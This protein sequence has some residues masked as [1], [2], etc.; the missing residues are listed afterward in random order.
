M[1]GVVKSTAIVLLVALLTCGSAFGQAVSQ[2]GG[3]TKDQSGAVVPGVQVTATQTDTGISRTA[4][5]NDAGEFVLPNLPT[6]PYRIEAKKTGFQNYAQSGIVLQVDSAPTIAITLGVGA[7]TQT[8]EVQANASQVETEKLG[9]GTVME[10]QRVLDLPLNGRNPTDLVVLTPG[11]VQTATSPAYGM[12]TGVKIAIAGGLDYGTFYALDGAPHMNLYDATNMPLPFP[13][14]LQEFKV[15]TSTQN[16]EVGVHAGGQVNAVTKSG[17]NSFHG[18]AFEFFR[19]GDLNAR[20][21]FSPTQDNLKRNQFGGVVG[22]PIRKNRLFF[23]GGYQGTELRQA[24]SP[25]QDYVPTPAM[26]TGDFSTF[27]SAGCQASGVQLNLKAPFVNNQIPQSMINP[28][29]LKIASYLPAAENQC[30]LF[31]T[32][33]LLS[34]YFWQVPLKID[35]QLNEK[36]NIFFRYLVT[37]QNQANPYSL[38]PKNI[39]SA[40]GNSIDDRAWDAVLGH[41][42]LISPTMINSLRFSINRTL[43]FHGGSSYFGPSQ[44]GMN[45][46]TYTPNAMQIAV[47]GDF[48]VGSGVDANDWQENSSGSV[49]DDFTLIKGKHQIAFGADLMRA[50]AISMANVYSIGSYSVTGAYTGSGLG[51]LFSGQLASVLQSL[52]NDLITDQWFFGAYAQ[53]TWKV[54]P[55]LTATFGLRWEP[56]LPFQDRDSHIYEFSLA[57]FYANQVSKVWTNAPPGFTYPGD[58]GFN[59]RSAMNAVWNDFAPRIGLAW[60]PFGDGKTSIRAGAGIGYDFFNSQLYANPEN[61][62]PFSGQTTLPGPLPLANPW[63]SIGGDPFPAYNSIPPTGDF[64]AGSAF[65]PVPRNLPPTRVYNWN[66]AIQRQITPSWFSSI[67]YMG[68]QGT[69]LLDMLNE[70]P[71]EFVPGNCV[72]GQYGLTAPGPCTNTANVNNRRLLTLA[73]PVAAAPIGYVSPFDAG[74]TSSYEGLVLATNYRMRQNLSVIANYTYSHC[75]SLNTANVLGDGTGNWFLYYV[76]QNDRNEDIGNCAQD[77]RVIANVTAVATMPKFSNRAVNLIAS[78][79]QASLLYRWSSGAPYTILSGLSSIY[80]NTGTERAQQVLTNTAAPNQGGACA[81]VAPC[82]SWLNPLAFAQPTT[83]TTGA[84]SNMGV[85]NVLGPSF[86][87]LDAAIV[88]Q[89]RIRENHRIEVRVEAFNFPNNVRFAGN[90]SSGVAI[91]PAV[92]LSTPTTFG[93]FRAANDPR[94]LQIAMKY[95]F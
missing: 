32:A 81:N 21:F 44:I 48:T 87:Q 64:P 70:N 59:G 27:A 43:V 66:F 10:N 72:A 6:G 25:A 12:N 94:I 60:D 93:Q 26:L 5:T 63:V 50:V 34:Q 84:L 35:Y 17:T 11:S 61:S 14:A 82:V 51:D 38:T 37:K 56:Y 74:A 77:R 23:F 53:D 7:V 4:T 75:I 95:V 28:V 15:D 2:I 19:N 83:A 20:N 13:D 1:T 49:N 16:A 89:F 24:P 47:T 40:G 85:F 73:N 67:T 92:T 86:V 69:H 91:A 76:H 45:S 46:Y 41:T 9:V 39:L 78:G 90:N 42:W 30:G 65:M 57:G 31:L 52:P 68:N 29:A 33:N 3:T 88:R 54:T 79:W 80:G 55:R 18:D 22:G 71:A 58:P 8:V 62:S 36:Q